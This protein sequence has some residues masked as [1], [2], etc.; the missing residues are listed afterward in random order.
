MVAE[1]A[2]LTY[3]RDR[4]IS[5]RVAEKINDK[6]QNI[7]GCVILFGSS[8]SN[9][10]RDLSKL[11]DKKTRTSYTFLKKIDAQLWFSPYDQLLKRVLFHTRK[12]LSQ[13]EETD[14]DTNQLQR[15]V[16]NGIESIEEV[17]WYKALF[18]LRLKSK[19]NKFLSVQNKTLSHK[20]YETRL[21]TLMN[22]LKDKESFLTFCE[23]QGM[24]RAIQFILTE[25][26]QHLPAQK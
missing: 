7:D 17:N 26:T 15:A 19:V 12:T 14:I 10:N 23:Q 25:E 18:A 11:I 9:I 16:L 1:Q 8:H 4:A 6:N 5:R 2:E 20:D 3:R 22:Q 24:A 21:H 13:S